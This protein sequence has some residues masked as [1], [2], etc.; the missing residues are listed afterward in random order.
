MSETSTKTNGFLS[1]FAELQAR[2]DGGGPEWLRA[3]RRRARTRFEE[4]GFPTTRDEA[5]KNTSLEPIARTVFRP[6]SPGAAERS[7]GLPDAAG[8]ELGGPRLVFR[9]GRYLAERSSGA[10]D[11]ELWIGSL[12]T[13][14]ESIPDRVRPLL[15][16]PE[17]E[18]LGVFEALNAAFAEDGAVV[19]VPNGLRL[20]EPIEIVYLGGGSQAPTAGLPRT[21]IVAGRDSRLTLVE[22]YVGAADVLYLTAPVTDLA[23]GRNAIVDHYRLQLDSEQAFHVSTIESRQE[24]DS[25]YRAHNLNLGGRLV[26]HDLSGVLEG[27]GARC[28]LFGLNLTHEAQHVDNHTTLDHAQ[29][30]CDSRELYKSILDGRSRSVFSGRIVVRPGAQKTDAK[31]SNPNLLLSRDALA[32]TRPQLEIYADDVKCT[33]GATIGRL[34]EDALF[35]LRSRGVEKTEARDLLIHAFAGEVLEQVTV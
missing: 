9:D 21:L 6:A 7:A 22:S 8:L 18:P 25:H 13:A 19:L 34:D 26:R 5:W 24:R 32:H 1:G 16:R 33:H 35:Y 12:A 23:L 27:E 14:L 11:G 10:R 17:A 15:A 30:H 29:P 3:L 4:R 28:D 20:T 2:L 31:Q